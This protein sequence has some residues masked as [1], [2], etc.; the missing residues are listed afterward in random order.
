MSV[1][2]GC[3]RAGIGL[4]TASRVAKEAYRSSL[5]LNPAWVRGSGWYAQGSRTEY[6][7]MFILSYKTRAMYGGVSGRRKGLF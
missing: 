1:I 4:K 2:G 6:F 3:P 7:V 5:Y